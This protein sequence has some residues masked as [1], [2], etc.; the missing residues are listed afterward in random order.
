MVCRFVG[1]AYDYWFDK[2]RAGL[3]GPTILDMCVVIITSTC[4][5]Y[6]HQ[7]HI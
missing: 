2:P 5:N 6:N 3:A 4:A 7:P 1:A